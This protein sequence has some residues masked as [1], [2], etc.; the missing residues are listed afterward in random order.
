M[1]GFQRA[2][3]FELCDTDYRPFTLSEHMGERIMLAFFPNAFGPVCIREMGRFGESYDMF[4]KANCR[5]IAVSKNS[6]SCLAE[7]RRRLGLP[8]TVLSDF[9]GEVSAR[10]SGLYVDYNGVKGLTLSRRAIFIIGSEL[11]IVYRWIGRMPDDEPEY[12][13]IEGILRKWGEKNAVIH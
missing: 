2:E 13:E 10:Y 11:E 3:D 1:P 4:Q 7:M 9:N 6:P 12:E 5:I 8:F